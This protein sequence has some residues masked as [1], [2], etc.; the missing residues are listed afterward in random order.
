MGCF[1]IEIETCGPNEALVV[2]GIIHLCICRICNYSFE[3]KLGERER[4]IL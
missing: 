1:G 2:S 4:D 3:E